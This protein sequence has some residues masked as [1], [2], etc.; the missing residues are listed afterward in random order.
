MASFVMFLLQIK[1]RV[2]T[3][4]ISVI[5]SENK[6]EN[7]LAENLLNFKSNSFA[8]GCSSTIF[9]KTN[10]K[11]NINESVIK[12]KQSNILKFKELWSKFV[13]EERKIKTKTTNKINIK[14]N[15][16]SPLTPQINNT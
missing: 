14:L 12:P 16:E 2:K 7:I 10:K 9:I 13:L 5:E 11:E 6:K 8:T 3:I 4:K 15:F 1:N